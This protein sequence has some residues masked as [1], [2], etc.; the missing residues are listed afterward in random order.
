MGNENSVHVGPAMAIGKNPDWTNDQV[1]F[2]RGKAEFDTTAEFWDAKKSASVAGVSPSCIE[3]FATGK[4]GVDYSSFPL[5]L[6]ALLYNAEIDKHM[7]EQ[8]LTEVTNFGCKFDSVEKSVHCDFTTLFDRILEECK[9][10][11]VRGFVETSEGYYNDGDPFKKFYIEGDCEKI[12][13]IHPSISKH[14]QF[15]PEKDWCP[16]YYGKEGSVT[17]ATVEITRNYNTQIWSGNN[18]NWQG[19]FDEDGRGR[20]L[21]PDTTRPI[22]GGKFI[23]DNVPYCTAFDSCTEDDFF[24]MA[25]AE[26][27]AYV[28]K[29]YDE[30]EAEKK[31]NDESLDIYDVK[32]TQTTESRSSKKKKKNAAKVAKIPKAR[33]ALRANN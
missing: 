16:A 25:N 22:D 18:R 1:L 19:I 30:E 24:R 31:V 2:G 27:N 17:F 7:Q 23:V 9:V 13:G 11:N 21:A 6:A 28:D 4:M 29:Y 20:A 8:G 10:L 12:L 15:N 26:A 32:I 33:K 14:K 3:T 5:R